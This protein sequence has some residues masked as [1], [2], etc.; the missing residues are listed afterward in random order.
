[1]NLKISGSE[2]NILVKL[3]LKMLKI[4][5]TKTSKNLKKVF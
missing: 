3:K 2:N 1:M 5:D 4:A